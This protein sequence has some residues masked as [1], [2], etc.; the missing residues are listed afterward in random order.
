MGQSDTLERMQSDFVYPQISD[1]RF[2]DDWEEDG[3]RDIRDV[4]LHRT[5]EILQSYYPNHI[6]E[7]LDVRLREKFDIRLPQAAMRVAK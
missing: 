2:I 1:R 4:A 7:D 5:R 3:A 6:S